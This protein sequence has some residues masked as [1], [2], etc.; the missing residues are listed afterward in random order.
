MGF[1]GLSGDFYPLLMP[2]LMLVQTH[3]KFIQGT[4]LSAKVTTFGKDHLRHNEL[5]ELTH[6]VTQALSPLQERR[7]GTTADQMYISLRY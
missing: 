6:A 7:A 1:C 2:T 4:D 3:T 5:P